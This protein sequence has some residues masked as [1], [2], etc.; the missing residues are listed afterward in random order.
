MSKNKY[1]TGEELGNKL[2]AV[3]L[4]MK[5]GQAARVTKIKPCNAKTSRKQ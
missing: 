2:L 5:S 3:V 4:E 1:M